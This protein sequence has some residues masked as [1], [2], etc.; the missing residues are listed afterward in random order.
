MVIGDY[1]CYHMEPWRWDYEIGEFD[2]DIC[3][4][5]IPTLEMPAFK[6]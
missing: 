1:G 5:I 2:N 3:W 4:T 6:N